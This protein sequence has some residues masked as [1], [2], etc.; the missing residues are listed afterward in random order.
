MEKEKLEAM[1]VTEL[2][3]LAPTVG[4]KNAKKYKKAELI[5]AIMA[6]YTQNDADGEN[7]N[8]PDEADQQLARRTEYI[9]GA[10]M[11]TMVAFKAPDG[12]VRSAKMINR[13]VKNRKLK[14]ET[15]Y[16]RQYVVSY[17]DVVWVRTNGRW[18]R[19]VYNMLKGMVADAN[20]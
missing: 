4:V 13:S 20:G 8:T 11:G 17:S 12:K 19:Y 15:A 10:E 18:P 2:R 6:T 3:K 1:K 9:E 7:N 14:L 16:G 5:D